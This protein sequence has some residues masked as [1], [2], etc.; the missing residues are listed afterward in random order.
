MWSVAVSANRAHSNVGLIAPTAPVYPYRNRGGLSIRQRLHGMLA[1]VARASAWIAQFGV[2]GQ[3]LGQTRRIGGFLPSVGVQVADQCA[4]GSSDLARRRVA[5]D[6]E[7]LIWTG[8]R[9]W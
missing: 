8:Y 6:A 9:C 7:D 5:G 4:V 1:V 3:H 2:G